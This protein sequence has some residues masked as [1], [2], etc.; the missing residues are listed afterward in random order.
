MRKSYIKAEIQVN[1]ETEQS[2]FLSIF[3]LFY[4][5]NFLYSSLFLCNR[6]YVKK[7]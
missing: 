5:I 7:S 4:K 3:E 6:L 2:L 1:E